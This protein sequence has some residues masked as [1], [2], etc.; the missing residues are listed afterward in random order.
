MRELG[1]AYVLVPSVAF[2]LLHL[3]VAEAQG[4]EQLLRDGIF[5]GALIGI[6]VGV[7]ARWSVV[8]AI[9]VAFLGLIVS[10]FTLETSS[11][12]V[13]AYLVCVAVSAM[14]SGRLKVVA[15]E[16][17]KTV[18]AE[19]RARKKV[20]A[21]QGEVSTLSEESQSLAVDASDALEQAIVHFEAR[22]PS[23]FWDKI[24]ECN[25]A[26]TQGAAKLQETCDEIEDYNYRK[27]KLKLTDLEDIEP[28]PPEAFEAQMALLES[29]RELFLKAH[30]VAEFALIFDH[31]RQTELVL[32]GQ[33][34]MREG[35]REMHA[36]IADLGVETQKVLALTS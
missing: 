26:L 30:G 36:D 15:A 12:S 31:R 18:A 6:G 33:R 28:L 4:I 1:N 8:V 2:A 14:V 13:Y 27:A 10:E 19:A 16:A 32:E 23:L 7:L 11:E 3:P 34:E 24:F 21:M 25:D 20:Q 17:R 5:W 22:R 29:M 9:I 35:Q